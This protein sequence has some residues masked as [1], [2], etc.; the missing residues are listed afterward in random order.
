MSFLDYW[1]IIHFSSGL[2]VGTVFVYLKRKLLY[3]KKT[4]IFFIFGFVVLV[5]WE[6]IEIILRILKH[7]TG[8]GIPFSSPE[9]YLN[10]FSD[11]IIGSIGLLII[12][13]IFNKKSK[14]KTETANDLCLMKKKL[15]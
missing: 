1:S 8:K 13:L 15:N 7:T 11:L 12:F 5:F 14:P 4:K 3:L 9:N 10:V 2:I 6:L